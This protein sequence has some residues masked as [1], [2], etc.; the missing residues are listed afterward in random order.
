MVDTVGN[1]LGPRAYFDYTTD[2]GRVLSVLMDESV[3][4]AV[5][6]EPASGTNPRGSFRGS[7]IVP[8]YILLQLVDDPTVRKR[9]VI[10][11]PDS[12]FM[13]SA[14]S[15]SIAINGVNWSQTYRSGER[16]SMVPAVI[17]EGP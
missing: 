13:T 10:T 1:R 11:E 16:L 6:N 5:G 9:V 4:L 14:T 7:G 8:R 2:D 17:P 15:A 12:G 3:A